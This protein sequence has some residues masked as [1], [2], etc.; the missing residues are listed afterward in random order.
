ML[1]YFSDLY[2]TDPH[3]GLHH[4]VN[5][6]W[7][8]TTFRGTY[9]CR[10]TE[11]TKNKEPKAVI[12]IIQNAD[13]NNSNDRHSKKEE[14][15]KTIDGTDKLEYFDKLYKLATDIDKTVDR[16]LSEINR[17][18]AITEQT[19]DPC[20][21]KQSKNVK[22]E[23]ELKQKKKSNNNCSKYEKNIKIENNSKD[24]ARS[25]DARI[26]NYCPPL[27]RI[28]ND[29]MTA[30]MYKDYNK[31][32]AQY[33]AHHPECNYFGCKY[34]QTSYSKASSYNLNSSPSQVYNN[35]APSDSSYKYH[36]DKVN[37][38]DNTKELF[39]Q[40]Y[41]NNWSNYAPTQTNPK[42]YRHEHSEETPK[43]S[44]TTSHTDNE[45]SNHMQDSVHKIEPHQHYH[46]KR[47]KRSAENE[48]LE[49][50][51]KNT[52]YDESNYETEY[53]DFYE[54]F[55]LKFPNSTAYSSE[56]TEEDLEQF[57]DL[58]YERFPYKR[59]TSEDDTN[60]E[61]VDTENY[62]E[63]EILA[64]TV[65][66]NNEESKNIQ[67]QI[68][69]DSNNEAEIVS[70]K[71]T[72][73]EEKLDDHSDKSQS[74][75]K[76]R[77]KRHP[78]YENHH[79][80]TE[81][82]KKS[83]YETEYRSFY[84]DYIS[85]YPK[86]TA[87][88]SHPEDEDVHHFYQLYYKNFPNKR[89]I[90]E[91]HE[92]TEN[93]Q[94][95]KLSDRLKKLRS[96]LEKFD[97]NKLEE[98]MNVEKSR[99]N[100]HQHHANAETNTQKKQH[101]STEKKTE[102][103]ESNYE[104]EYRDF[105]NEYISKYPEST[106]FSLQPKDEDVK[107]FNILYYDKFPYKRPKPE[108]T[109]KSENINTHADTMKPDT[110]KKTE[111]ENNKPKYQIK[112][113]DE[114]LIDAFKFPKNRLSAKKSQFNPHGNQNHNR[115][116][117]FNENTEHDESKYEEEYRDFYNRYIS[118]YPK[119]TAFSQQPKDEDVKHFNNLYYNKFPYKRNKT[120]K[121]EKI[122][123]IDKHTDTLK[124]PNKD[125]D[126]PKYQIK[127]V[128]D[129][130]IDDP[131]NFLKPRP[132]DRD[133]NQNR[134]KNCDHDESDYEKEYQNFY[135][136][137]L[138]KYPCSTA[139]SSHPKDEDVRHFY[140]LYYEKFPYK[141]PKSE[142][143]KKT[144]DTQLHTDTD[145]HNEDEED[146]ET[147][148]FITTP[149]DYV[150]TPDQDHHPEDFWTDRK[151]RF[152]H[153]KDEAEDEDEDEDKF[154][155][156]LTSQRSKYFPK[157]PAFKQDRLNRK[158]GRLDSPV[159]GKPP[160]SAEMKSLLSSK[161]EDILRKLRERRSRLGSKFPDYERVSQWYKPRAKSVDAISSVGS[162]GP[163]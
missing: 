101:L 127:S 62:D 8:S 83:N 89:P 116:T 5:S 146:P 26:H 93:T 144:E 54:E 163:L 119:S 49:E 132:D 53:S 107:H 64:T 105:Y 109:K 3:T 17:H 131:Y 78:G 137:Y 50:T 135:R 122:E 87:F 158:L 7:P 40:D 120:D 2:C 48:T 114:E 72:K 117:E 138:A 97:D 24:D 30:A 73:S 102:H 1:I 125:N 81:E 23:S 12:Q 16:S 51:E 121:P 4:S 22:N 44:S 95:H 46:Y 9:A 96:E 68:N 15:A 41:D 32:L 25:N 66:E 34:D 91:S 71:S 129:K 14:T 162:Y 98:S 90:S 43:V 29:E 157:F 38:S 151:S 130:D 108:D 80:I 142:N 31:Y 155:H 86:S 156:R 85:K 150:D 76:K 141:L 100:S 145:E 124:N 147:P 106:A 84:N 52:Q 161:I 20:D 148:E 111:L 77:S 159:F 128:D 27:I 37:N 139:Y 79:T 19:T 18:I 113:D 13:E 60:V 92:N 112:S 88:S 28:E 152:Y 149:D 58:Y 59:P 134:H 123:N 82:T 143:T 63:D 118:M 99:S 35:H 110:F 36:S 103:D 154:S 153:Q 45:A 33:F 11:D 42:Q 57:Y 75:Q 67:P 10:I 136:E 126:E 39:D 70:T 61:D 65:S 115:Q 104:T 69:G 55:I 74:Q 94:M 56:P 21:E 140:R 47:N 6:K 160:G 133:S